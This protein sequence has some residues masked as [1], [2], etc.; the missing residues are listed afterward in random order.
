MGELDDWQS[1]KGIG[2]TARH[3]GDLSLAITKI[4]EAIAITRPI[5][6]LRVQTA[7]ML[8]YLA[9][10]YILNEDF[11]SAKTTI[12]EAIEVCQPL[13]QIF[14]GDNLLMLSDIDFNLKNYP[15]ALRAAEDGSRIHIECNHSHGVERAKGKIN[16]IMK[17]LP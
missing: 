6:K 10:L 2:I 17:H 9:D 5:E 4:G 1:L 15:D 3:C 16:A 13:D 8:N 7:S 12:N 14:M 11:D